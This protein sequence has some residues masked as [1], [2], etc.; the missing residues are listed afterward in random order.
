MFIY[1]IVLP[2]AWEAVKH[3]SNYSAESLETEGFIHC[4]YD[5]QLDGVIGRYYSASPEL[6]I[7]KLDIG[8][9]TSK[10]VSEPSTGGE[11]YPHIYG[12]INLDAVVD[13]SVRTGSNSDRVS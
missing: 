3:N 5:H 1:H 8:K 10:L 6:V 2:E 13:T 9:L 7:L 4:S 12:S 11:V